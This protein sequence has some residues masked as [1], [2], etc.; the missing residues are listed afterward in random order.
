MKLENLTLVGDGE[1]DE[2]PFRVEMSEEPSVEASRFGPTPKIN[3]GENISK[4][5]LELL[6][7]P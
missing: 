3:F 4:A 2:S 6:T 5:T 1:I 7:I